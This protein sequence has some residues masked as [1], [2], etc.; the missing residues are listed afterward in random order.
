LE[1]T[2]DLG[3]E[4]ER[5]SKE[6]AGVQSQI[7]RLEKLLAGEFASRAPAAVV[8]KE[9]ERLAGYRET[10]AKLRSQLGR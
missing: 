5:L 4:R 7:Q 3:K 6:L 8:D 10:E 2:V 1:G 9:R